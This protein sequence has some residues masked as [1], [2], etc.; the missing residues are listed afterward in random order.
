MGAASH[1][2]IAI[3]S[4]IKTIMFPNKALLA[5]KKLLR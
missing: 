5:E 3:Q 4:N 2:T 1:P